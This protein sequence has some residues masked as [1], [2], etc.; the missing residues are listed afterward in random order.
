LV[1]A[2]VPPLLLLLLL[3]SAV[4]AAAIKHTC[5]NLCALSGTSDLTLPSAAAAAAAAAA[6]KHTICVHWAAPVT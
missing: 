3:L 4:P 1:A 5:I 2:A 6:I